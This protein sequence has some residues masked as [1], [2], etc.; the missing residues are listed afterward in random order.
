MSEYTSRYIA[1]NIERKLR[2]SMYLSVPNA[3]TIRTNAQ[4]KFA[5]SLR[6]IVRRIIGLTINQSLTK[7]I[8]FPKEVTYIFKEWDD[9]IR[10]YAKLLIDL[11]HDI[12]TKEIYEKL[13]GATKDANVNY[14]FIKFCDMMLG[15]GKVEEANIKED[16]KILLNAAFM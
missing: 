1:V 6:Y 13:M 9:V 16:V 15:S 10:F 11:A 5:S 3:K 12:S 8:P 2:G 4:L 7:N 14:V